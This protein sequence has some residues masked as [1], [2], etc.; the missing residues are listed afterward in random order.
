MVFQ[1]YALFPN[2]TVAENIGSGLRIG[3]KPKAEIKARVDEML[4]LIHMENFH[5]RYPGQLSGGQQQRVALARALAFRPQAL[6]LDEPL[7]ALDAKIRVEL[8]LEIRRIQ[9]QLGITTI[10]VTHDQEEALSL[11]DRI[12]VMSQGRVEQIGTPYEIYKTP[13]TEF[14]AS[15]VGQLNLIPVKILDLDAK[16][17]PLA[18]HLVQAGRL[19]EKFSPESPCLA[20]R[21]EE[22]NPGQMEGQNNLQG[23]VESIH[24]LGSIVRIRV[25]V[26]GSHFLMDLFNDQKLTIPKVGNSYDFYFP[27]DACWLI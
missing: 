26:N 4:A 24:Y 18:G 19:A 23:I 6:L 7:S 9:Q 12:V 10:Y 15:F 17:V 3:G 22:I 16:Q 2:M 1:S 11:S 5:S 8:R 20:V 21:P 27:V 25:D 14:V 13:A